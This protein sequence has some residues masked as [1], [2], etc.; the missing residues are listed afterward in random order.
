MSVRKTGEQI[1]IHFSDSAPSVSIAECGKLFERLYR[2]DASRSRESGG[3]GLGLSI[4]KS[5]VAAHQG[6]IRA[7]PSDLGGL[8]IIIVLP[9][10]QSAVR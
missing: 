10:N 2:A 3:A 4:C 8:E 5:I 1:H 6:T 7:Q 9:E